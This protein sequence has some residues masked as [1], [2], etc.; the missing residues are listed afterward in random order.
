MSQ[1]V[2]P[3]LKANKITPIAY[4]YCRSLIIYSIFHPATIQK[5]I[6]FSFI[7]AEI[8][9]MCRYVCNSGSAMP[10]LYYSYLFRLPQPRRVDG[11]DLRVPSC[12]LMAALAT[13]RDVTPRGTTMADGAHGMESAVPAKRPRLDFPEETSSHQCDSDFQYFAGTSELLSGI[14]KFLSYFLNF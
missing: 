11:V 2:P 12:E 1:E 8:G 7:H 5:C 13:R 4:Y 14:V 3:P 9:T 6:Q 10:P